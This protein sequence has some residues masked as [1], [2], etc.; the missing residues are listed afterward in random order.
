MEICC[1]TARWKSANV[2]VIRSFRLTG[3][4]L[5]RR[6]LAS[7]IRRRLRNAPVSAASS[8]G[9]ARRANTV[10]GGRLKDQLEV[11]SQHGE[12][13]IEIMRESGG[14]AAC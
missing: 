1:P 3:R 6:F 12:K 4:R 5:V 13:I 10:V 8:A 7:D 2:S 9:R 14:Q 11:R